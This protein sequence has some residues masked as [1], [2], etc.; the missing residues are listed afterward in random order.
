MLWHLDIFSRNTLI[1]N[2]NR[3]IWFHCIII[4][5]KKKCIMENKSNDR[6]QRPTPVRTSKGNVIGNIIVAP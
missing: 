2:N 5:M 6:M 3:S 1:G 4:K